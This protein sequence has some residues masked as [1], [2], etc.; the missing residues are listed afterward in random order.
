MIQNYIKIALR[1]LL[2]HRLFSG[3]NLVGLAASMSL[4]LVIIA[5]LADL[6]RFDEFHERKDR[7]F[8]VISHT[9]DGARRDDQATTML[10]LAE[11]LRAGA[12]GVEEVVR[13]RRYFGGEATA[14]EKKLPLNGHFADPGF[15]KIFSFPMLYGDP[16]E[17]LREPFSVVITRKTMDKVFDGKNPLGEQIAVG[18]LGLFKVTGVLDDI[19]K[20]SHLQFEMLGSF[21]TVAALERQENIYP[22]S[23]TWTETQLYYIYLLLQPGSSPKPIEDVLN[24]VAEERYSQLE[25]YSARFSLQPLTA[26]VP[27]R[28]LSDQIGP[29]MH[30][31]ALVV[32]SSLALVVL[33]SACFN[34]TNLS[35]AR[36]IRRSREIGVR[37]VIGASRRQIF[38]QFLAEAMTLSVFALIAGVAIFQFIKSG[39]LEAIPRGHAML[40]LELSPVLLLCFVGFALLTGVMAGFV[41]ALV[42]SKMNPVSLVKNSLSQGLLKRVSLR[43]ALIVFQFVICLAFILGATIA[44]RQYRFA[45]SHN[46]G[47]TKE[48]ILNVQLQG[49]DYQR[50]QHEFSLIPEVRQLSFSSL[51][52]GTGSSQAAWVQAQN[53]QDSLV[54]YCMSVDRNFLNNHEIELASGQ[55]FPEKM[56]QAAERFILVNERF[57]D[58]FQWSPQQ[59]LDQIVLVS[60]LPHRI[61]GVV[62]DFNYQHL[63]EPIGKFF[64]RY[65]PEEFAHANLK[66]SSTDMTATMTTLGKTWDKM[67]TGR[68]FE[69]KFFETQIEE[70]YSFLV[71]SVRI[72]GFLA[73]IAIAIACLGLLGMAVY[74]TETRLK[75]VTLRKIFGATQWQLMSLLSKGFVKMLL[76][77][78]VIALPPVYFL[79]DSVV[80]NQFAFR[81]R[82]G[83]VELGSGVVLLMTLGLLMI[84]SQIWK[85]ATAAPAE[86]LRSE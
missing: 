21:S 59:A 18:D 35:L 66:I 86:S 50:F 45:L 33:L 67:A 27:G 70:T 47:F 23:E 81:I 5:M 49:A 85:A 25:D 84:G 72:F 16:D 74:T 22:A 58:A 20:Y 54:A 31:V 44:Y 68:D 29:K 28:D 77:A 71:N 73:F 32:L 56:P 11:H 12:G 63:E 40:D 51:I 37:K 30:P 19:P 64:F 7:I 38:G 46:M 80:L 41:P 48:N 15:L 24:R 78:A 62:K 34:Y 83:V 9:V 6:L 82:L 1:N 52:P 60:D 3:I 8:R 55:N 69:A 75:E 4:G 79:F 43:K 65:E 36:A 26:I 13:V 39:F 76:L 57:A 61:V 17:A 53:M 10:P 2:R 14:N 42:L